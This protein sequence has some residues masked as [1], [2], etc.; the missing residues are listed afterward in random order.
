MKTVRRPPYPKWNPGYFPCSSLTTLP[1]SSRRPSV[2]FGGFGL[3]GGT[4]TGDGQLTITNKLTWTGGS[5][6]GSGSTV[7]SSG[8]GMAISGS[9][10]KTLLNRTVT[11]NGTSTWSGTGTVNIGNEADLNIGSTGSADIQS[12]LD[13]FH[14][15]GNPPG[16]NNDGALTKSG[17]NGLTFISAHFTNNGTT[18]ITSGGTLELYGS[19]I[20]NTGTFVAGNP[21]TIAFR[22]NTHELATGSV[23]SGPGTF[24]FN[25]A[26]VNFSGTYNATGNTSITA[27]AFNV[28]ATNTAPTVS[29]S[30]G[31]QG[32]SAQLN[33]SNELTWT[34]GSFGGSGSTVISSG[35]GMAVSGSATKTLLN[36]TVTV[37]GTS[38]WSGTGTV[39][40]GNEAD[41]NIGSTG[42]ADIQSD[43]DFFHCCG[44]PPGFNN[45]GALTK[46]GGN[47]L[48]FISAHFT[49]NGT[50]SIT[51]SGTLEL[52]GSGIPNTGTFV[53]GNPSTIAFR[54]NTH[55]LATGSVLSGPGTFLFNG[56]IVNFS[57]TYNATGNTSITAGAFN[58]N[59]TN[60]APTV[61]L[62]GGTQGGS[63]QLNVSN[64]LAW[65]GG[66][67]GGSGSTVI[68][69]GAGMAISGSATKTLLNRT[70]TVNGTSTWS[71]TG[72]VNI[73]NEADLNIGSTGSA[74]IQSDLDFFH[75]C[76]NPPGFNNDGAL[77]K[78]GGN[79]LTF[80]SAH[81]TNNGTTSITSGGTLELHGSGIPN[82][83]TFVA[84]NPSTIAFRAN[85]HELATG[86]V[87]SGPGTF[88]F[89]G[90]IVN[91]SG[92]YNAT[93]N[94]SIT[95]GAFNVNATNTAPTVS[96]SG[97]TQGG[98]CSDQRLQRA[99]LDR[100]FLRRLGIN[101]HLVR[102]GHGR[103]RVRHQDLAQQDCHRQRHFYLVRYWDRQHRQRCRSQHRVNRFR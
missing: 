74:D 91:F 68:S 55:E 33:V 100:R 77:T 72:T 88:L 45:D 76:G 49:N 79:G 21:S 27:G 78:S 53:A 44:N 81:F 97:G 89:N 103:L 18:S 47:G 102:S 87:L 23:L 71:G 30:G 52:Y 86:S 31:T 60:T 75:C 10:T 67:F 94:T 19:G 83:G 3:S 14:C 13:F 9:A 65:T 17:G 43:L 93:G 62:S 85:T 58:V 96:L 32:G 46:S 12:D 63:A 15:C 5:F 56:A 64:E 50:T 69:S 16:F 22:A 7:I 73:G 66:S 59:A 34:G 42:S 11:V 41:L 84:G 101:R 70:V 95:A 37:N 92:T 35:V 1:L 28:N 38:T 26:I 82:T 29:L 6:E 20:P 40:I 36:R 25:G 39:S 8:A 99:H 98:P 80:I 4:L 57:G 48:T 2:S 54:A 51:S 90:A 61:S 24:L